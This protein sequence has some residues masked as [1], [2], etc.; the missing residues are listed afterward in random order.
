VQGNRDLLLEA[1]LNLLSNA[2]AHTADQGRIAVTCRGEDGRAVI[3]VADDGPGIPESERERIFDRFYRGPGRPR[4]GGG[5]GSGLGLP[6]ARRLVE[7]HGG[8]LTARNGSEGGAVFSMV[9]PLQS[10]P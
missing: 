8:S 4:R 3:E 10:A 9:I 2:V 5:G 7:V 6:I 1:L